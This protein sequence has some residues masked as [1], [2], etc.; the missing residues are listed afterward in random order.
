MSD[1]YQAIFDAVPRFQSSMKITSRPGK[2]SFLG[3]R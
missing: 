2:A 3:V 1:N